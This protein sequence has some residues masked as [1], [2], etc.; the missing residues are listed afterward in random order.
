MPGYACSI[1]ERMLYSSCKNHLVD[2]VESELNLP[3]EKK[4]KANRIQS[5]NVQ[6]FSKGNLVGHQMSPDNSLVVFFRSN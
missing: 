2:W 5:L 6:S 4:V 1:K 3:I